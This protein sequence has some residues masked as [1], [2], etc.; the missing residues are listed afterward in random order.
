MI[1]KATMADLPR[2]WEVYAAARQYMRDHGN[3]VQWD[4]ED[5]P[6]GKLE[7]DIRLGRLYVLDEDGIR[8]VFAFIIGP[9]DT[10]AVI[11]NGAWHSDTTYGTLHRLGSDGT[12]KHVMA[13]VFAWMT[14]QI[15]HL[16]VD[17][18]ESNLTMQLAVE[19]CGFRRCG[20][21]YE[22]DGT[23]RLAYDWLK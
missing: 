13:T 16:R 7:N 9:D 11:E 5:A 1:R 14:A 22:P 10:Y 21:I 20:I 4:G 6:E 19:R 12:R 23:P 8:G 17:T 18:H 15:D 3:T 2:I